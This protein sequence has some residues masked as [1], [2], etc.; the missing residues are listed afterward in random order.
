MPTQLD[1]VSAKVN[2]KSAYVYYVSTTQINVLTPLDNTQGAVQIIVANGMN[3]SAPFT[4]N[5][6]AAA[7]SFLLSGTSKYIAATHADGSLLGPASMSVPGYVLTPAQPGET[8]VL[9]STGFG[10]PNGTLIDGSAS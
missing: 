7:P 5:L 3:S 4:S 1:S 8:V 10:L 9:Y 2:G 6:R